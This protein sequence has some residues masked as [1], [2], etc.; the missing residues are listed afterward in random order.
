MKAMKSD[1]DRHWNERARSGIDAAKVNID[2]TVQRDLELQFVFKNIDRGSR[3]LEVGCGN[4]FVTQQ[5]RERVAYVDAFDFAENMVERGRQIYGETNNRFFHDSVLDP[6]NTRGPYDIAVCMRVLINL[7]N[8]EEQTKALRNIAALVRPGGKLILI[9]GYREGFEAISMFRT[10]LGMPALKPAS[11]NY[12]SALFELMPAVQREFTIAD[13]FHTGLFDFLTRIVY[14]SL[15]DP[16]RATH[17]GEFHSKVE[18]I[19]RAYDG[20]DLARFARLH[21]FLLFK[22]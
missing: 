16:D 13:T 4:G 3:L 10:K 2:D 5:L 20:P 8:L 15:V 12:Y 1:T 14:P 9:E 18:P 22:R 17:A 21:G 7:R 6:K 11:I 19:V